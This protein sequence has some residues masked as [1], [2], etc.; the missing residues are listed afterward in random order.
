MLNINRKFQENDSAAE[1]FHHIFREMA[2]FMAL[3]ENIEE[4][5]IAREIALESKLVSSEKSL[6]EQLTK[7]KESFS[8]FES[9]MT[10]AGA[11]RWR[12][13]AE[14]AVRQG[15]EHLQIL[16]NVSSA[17]AQT[18]VEGC[19]RFERIA[20]KSLTKLT[21]VSHSIPTADFQLAAKTG[22]KQLKKTSLSGIKRVSKLVTNLHLKSFILA[23]LMTIFVIFVTGLYVNDEWPWE[24]HS[25]VTK[26]RNIGRALLA[27]WPYL[28]PLEQEDII[29]SSKRR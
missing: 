6:A 29:N 12:I 25:Q 8:C 26:E 3:Y 1:Q 2:D 14:N 7:I 11:A 23:T 9:I 21:E 5:I 13:A 15:N 27:A 10:E 24:I 20:S 18:F 22:C 4:K 17:S 16:K 19:D 28:S